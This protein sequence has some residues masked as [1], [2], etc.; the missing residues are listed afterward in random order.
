MLEEVAEP[1]M[2]KTKLHRVVCVGEAWEAEGMLLV[3]VQEV[4]EVMV[5]GREEVMVILVWEF[6]FVLIYETDLHP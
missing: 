1:L 5:E 6:F 2:H 3:T 4:M